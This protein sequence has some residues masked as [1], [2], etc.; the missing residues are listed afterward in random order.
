MAPPD[1]APLPSLDDTSLVDN[2]FEELWFGDSDPRR[3][4]EEASQSLAAAAGKA[5]GLKPFPVVAQRVIALLSN[6][7]CGISEVHEE[8]ERDPALTARILQVANSVAFRPIHPYASINEAIVRLGKTTVE[9]IVWGVATMQLFDDVTGL[10]AQVRNHT[11]AVAGIVRVLAY[12]WGS[13]N[14]SQAFIA[15]MFHDIGK[16]LSLQVR[17]IDY[18]SFSDDHFGQPDALHLM[19]RQTSGY[20]HAVL[21]AHVME[22]WGLPRDVCRAVAWHHQPGRAYEVGGDVGLTVALVRL[23]NN[24][25]YQLTKSTEVDELYLERLVQAG[26]ASYSG[27]GREILTA[28]WPKLVEAR[29]ETVSVFVR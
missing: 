1:Y 2:V 7:D 15:G 23:A 4:R 26:D 5:A 12:E 17:E 3:T 6:P 24:I 10:G 29:A 11:A 27:Y 16:L 19:E 9:E 28:M 21:G 13:Q 14:V 25:E 18:K 20:D 8:I 22:D